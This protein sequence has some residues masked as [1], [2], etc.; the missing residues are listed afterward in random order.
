MGKT[1]YSD[2]LAMKGNYFISISHFGRKTVSADIPYLMLAARTPKGRVTL[3]TA[4]EYE[5]VITR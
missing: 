5:A 1:N 3:G 2:M 4:S